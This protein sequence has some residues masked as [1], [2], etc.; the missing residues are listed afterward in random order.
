MLH[1]I[2]V[3]FDSSTG[4]INVVSNGDDDTPGQIINILETV[5]RQLR[6]KL[7]LHEIIVHFDPDKQTVSS[8]FSDKEIKTWDYHGMILQLAK[9]Q[10]DFNAWFARF[11]FANQRVDRMQQEAMQ[12]EIL[13]SQVKKGGLFKG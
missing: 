4:K 3:T 7:G 2:K 9:D 11:M 1:E 5:R 6:E 8:S 12:N 10:G 13:A